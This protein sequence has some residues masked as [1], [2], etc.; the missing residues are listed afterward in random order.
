M[1]N[2]IVEIAPHRLVSGGELS[3]R[4][5]PAMPFIHCCRFSS[6][7]VAGAQALAIIEGAANATAALMKLVSGYFDRSQ[8]AK[9]WLIVA[10]PCSAV[11][12]VDR[13]GQ[14][15]AGGA[16]V[17]DG[18]PDRQG[19]AHQSTRDALLAAGAGGPPWPPHGLHRS[20]DHAGAV[21][22]PLVAALLAAGWSVREK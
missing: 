14:F 4:F 13:A 21:A 9:G 11:A 16:A 20:M 6:A 18:R 17:A 2:A 10:T 3:Q 12:S 7:T 15:N 5:R 19:T 1:L 22:G 8:R